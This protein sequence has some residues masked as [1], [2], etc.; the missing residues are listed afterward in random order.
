MSQP[1]PGTGPKPH[2]LALSVYGAIFALGVVVFG[3]GHTLAYMAW[4]LMFVFFFFFVRHFSFAI[5]AAK[6]VEADLRAP[7]VG[8]EEFTPAVQVV[9][10]C[11][12]EELV[13]DSLARALLSLDYPSDRLSVLVV[14]DASTDATGAM[15]D[16]WSALDPRLAVLHRPPGAG[17]G[18]SGALNDAL[19]MVTAPVLVIFDADHEPQRNAI[20]RLVRHFRDPEV[21]C[22]MGRCIIR[23]G[24]ED[25]FASV[26]F[27]D[28]LSGY[29]VNEY[30][31]QALF[32]LP[33]YGGANCAVRRSTLERLGG[34]NPET[35]T[36]DTDLTIRVVLSGGRVRY[37]PTAVDFE[38]AVVSAKRFWR[39]RYRWSRGHQ[40]C[41]RDYVIPAIRC[42]H[43]SLPE[44]VE[45]LMFLAIYHIPVLSALG[46]IL[47][48]LRAFGIGEVPAEILLP[49]TLL[50]F[51]GPLSELTV[52]LL[53]GKV[54][55]RAAW[56]IL[57]F[58]PSYALSILTTTRAYFDGMFGQPYTWVKTQRSGAVAQTV[59]VPESVTEKVLEPGGLPVLAREAVPASP[60][61]TTG[62]VMRS[63]GRGA[64]VVGT[65]TF[66]DRRP[67]SPPGGDPFPQA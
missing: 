17:G 18:K 5:A 36:E 27:I 39:Q 4:G 28:F 67:S 62:L 60:I 35:V 7:D 43:L 59:G 51:L 57:G 10:A 63:G 6:W 45:F 14:D 20:S 37:D 31:R 54:E 50:M 25:A 61:L 9:V 56:T 23:N 65:R 34:W 44:K 38:E 12:N 21:E 49:L 8:L 41:A 53:L 46:V 32:E 40:Q 1:K 58:L 52:A 64:A 24:A 42:P 16:R 47:T 2:Y 29:L 11:K 13:V 3:F 22:V 66:A 15:L 48:V 26:V 33:A 55:R 19:A 30:G